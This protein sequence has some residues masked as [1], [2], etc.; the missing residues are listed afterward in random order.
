[1]TTHGMSPLHVCALSNQ[2]AVAKSLLD[3]GAEINVISKNG[4][5]LSLSIFRN[6][7]DI[8]QLLLSRGTTYET[9]SRTG[10]S[11]LHLAALSGGLRTL[12]ILR[13]A[14]L[15]NVDPDALSR[16][17]HNA[18]QLALARA[19][20]PDGFVK[21]FQRLLAD[22]RLRNADLKNTR[23]TAFSVA[24]EHSNHSRVKILHLMLTRMK[25]KYVHQTQSFRRHIGLCFRTVSFWYLWII[26]LAPSLFWLFHVHTRHELSQ[27]TLGLG[28]WWCVFS[29]EDPVEPQ[30]WR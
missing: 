7:D 1:M 8:T 14:G 15:Q 4:E 5:A 29:P 13:D 11:I 30:N 6:A 18:I 12:N 28:F 26:L 23:A 10:Y 3:K 22:I 2:V 16:L 21:E 24:P 27:V 19:S 9:W 20:K 25:T 17:G